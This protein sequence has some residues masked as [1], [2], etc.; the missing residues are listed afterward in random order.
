M[1]C[2][3]IFSLTEAVDCGNSRV[4][5]KAGQQAFTHIPTSGQ[6][7]C[8]RPCDLSEWPVAPAGSSERHRHSLQ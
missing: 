2:I 4:S 6:G 7:M 8:V 3:C 5:G 1:E